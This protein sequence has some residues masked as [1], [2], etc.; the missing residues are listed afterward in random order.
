MPAS[1]ICTNFGRAIP[2]GLA[3]LP[4]GCAGRAKRAWQD[5]GTS[6]HGTTH[7]LHIRR[8]L[9]LRRASSGYARDSCERGLWLSATGQPRSLATYLQKPLP[10]HGPKTGF[11]S[12]H[13]TGAQNVGRRGRPLPRET[14]RRAHRGLGRVRSALGLASDAT[15]CKRGALA[16]D[17]SLFSVAP[18]YL[19]QRG[20]PGDP[21]PQSVC[22]LAF[23]GSAFSI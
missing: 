7:V 19:A 12:S 6:S 20:D 14:A 3:L 13:W 11:V 8:P 15:G 10:L 9:V 17:W 16:E 4:D 1:S 22:S 2:I 23:S 21:K 5:F 18:R